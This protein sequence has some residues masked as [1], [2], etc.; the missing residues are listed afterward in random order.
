MESGVRRLLE[1][2][3]AQETLVSMTHHC[4]CGRR[5][6]SK[7][8]LVWEGWWSP[9]SLR[10]ELSLSD[11]FTVCASLGSMTG[12]RVGEASKP[13]TVSMNGWLDR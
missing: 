1:T 4:L 8:G 5:Q 9:D 7:G 3:R 12:G 10:S 13:I 11:N 2:P 6:L